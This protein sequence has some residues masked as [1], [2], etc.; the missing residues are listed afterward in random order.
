MARGFPKGLVTWLAPG[1]FLAA[2]LLGVAL[3]RSGSSTWFGAVVLALVAA[4]AAWVLVSALSPARADRRC[5]SCAREALARQSQDSTQ[6]LRCTACGWT[7]AE[8]S[9]WMLAEEEGPL[10]GIVLAERGRDSPPSA[11]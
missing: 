2:A 11:S 8:A 4:P 9:A 3:V 5:P 10:E 6:G 7:D 1:L